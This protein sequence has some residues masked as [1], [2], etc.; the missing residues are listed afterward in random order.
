MKYILIYIIYI[1]IWWFVSV[2]ASKGGGGVA[3]MMAAGRGRTCEGMMGNHAP[4][5][6]GYSAAILRTCWNGSPLFCNWH[7]SCFG[8]SQ[9]LLS[10]FLVSLGYQLSV[11]HL[12]PQGCKTQDALHWGTTS[13]FQAGGRGEGL[14][15]WKKHKL[16]HESP[17]LFCLC[18]TG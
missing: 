13:M 4:V 1:Y 12:S 7:L 18:L 9:H 14:S 17:T 11:S 3:G 5:L 16:P 6:L 15:L 8:P 10:L 2:I